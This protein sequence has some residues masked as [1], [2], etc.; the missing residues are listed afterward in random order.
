MQIHAPTCMLQKTCRDFF[1]FFKHIFP[2]LPCAP[3][4]PKLPLVWSQNEWVAT[5]LLC[6][7]LGLCWVCRKTLQ[8]Q[9]IAPAFGHSRLAQ[10]N[11]ARSAR[12]PMAISCRNR[13]TK[14]PRGAHKTGQKKKNLG[15]V[16]GRGGGGAGDVECKITA[17]WA[18]T[19]VSSSQI[20]AQANID[21]FVP[22]CVGETQSWT[23]IS[24]VCECAPTHQT[25][26][27]LL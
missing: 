26:F 7:G 19:Q 8:F 20:C 15:R 2:H 9:R 10:H 14:M 27:I 24:S 3:P 25:Q 13:N 12:K 23:V 16:W 6:A 18:T 22:R 1:F 4:T 17:N 21:E 11:N 5:R